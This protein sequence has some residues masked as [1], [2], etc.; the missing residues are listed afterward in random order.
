MSSLAGGIPVLAQGLARF[1]HDRPDLWIE[2][3]TL[4]ADDA[5]EALRRFDVDLATLPGSSI[6][7][8]L[9]SRRLARWRV[10]L[11]VRPDHVFASRTRV[12]IEDLAAE[13]VLML[14][15]EFVVARH[16]T[17]MGAHAGVRL[18]IRLADASPEAVVSL[19]RRGWGV[20]VLPDSVRLPRG[21]VA[22]PLAGQPRSSEFDYAVAWRRERTLPTAARELVRVLVAET[23]AF[24]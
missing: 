19:A 14:A 22:V 1:S 23:A 15:P 6:G 3:R 2:L 13:P 11:A 20:G 17:A 24:R 8:D 16:V 12:T 5:V 4:G 7:P 10:V 9:D 18:R 21:L